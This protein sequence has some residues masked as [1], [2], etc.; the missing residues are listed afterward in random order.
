MILSDKSLLTQLALLGHWTLSRIKLSSKLQ[1][2]TLN[3][4]TYIIV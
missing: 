4:E 3:S 2:N 1:R